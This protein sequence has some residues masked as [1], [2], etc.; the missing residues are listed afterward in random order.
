MT[1]VQF[2]QFADKNLMIEDITMCYVTETETKRNIDTYVYL[3][4]YWEYSKN[5]YGRDVCK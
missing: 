1:F 4:R 3:L 2:A 5:F